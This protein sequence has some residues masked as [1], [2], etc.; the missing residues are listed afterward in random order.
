M[1]WLA[2]CMWPP[3]R[4][5]LKVQPTGKPIKRRVKIFLIHFP[6]PFSP[7]LSILKVIF[8]SSIFF[9]NEFVF[10]FVHIIRFV[11]DFVDF[12]LWF[13]LIGASSSNWF[14]NKKVN[15]ACAEIW[16]LKDLNF[17]I[18]LIIYDLMVLTFDFSD[19]IGSGRV[20][21]R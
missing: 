4:Q 2:I 15:F 8:S 16:N 1:N 11:H 20:L 21:S 7:I 10:L 9:L 14:V 19:Q 3:P 17:W 6:S 5:D 18:V 13:F 12:C